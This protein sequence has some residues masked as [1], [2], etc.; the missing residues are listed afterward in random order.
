MKKLLILTFLFCIIFQADG[1][2]RKKKRKKAKTNTA[3]VQKKD[4]A[5]FKSDV[6]LVSF[7]SFGP[8]ID[9]RSI[10]VFENSLKQFNIDN[11]CNVKYEMKPWGREGE[12]DYCITAADAKC[13]LN[14][15]RFITNNFKGNDRILIKE[16][17]Q[18]R[19]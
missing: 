15:A 5:S 18:C 14:F 12:R 19:H 7:I 8:G 17:A 1:F 4:S 16:H 10:P 13:L 2:C 11:Q 6:L 3:V 9:F